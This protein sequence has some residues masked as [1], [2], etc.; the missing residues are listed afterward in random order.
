VEKIVMRNPQCL[1]QDWQRMFIARLAED[2][3]IFLKNHVKIVR[4]GILGRTVF[5]MTISD[6]RI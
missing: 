5:K 4:I 3:L 1:L 6:H 2:M